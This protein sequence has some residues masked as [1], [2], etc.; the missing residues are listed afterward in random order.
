MEC[1][2]CHHRFS[3]SQHPPDQHVAIE[4]GDNYFSG[5]ENCYEDYH[6]QQHELIRQGKYYSEILKRYAESSSQQSLKVLDIGSAS[7]CILKGMVDDGWRGLGIE[8]N[9][10]MVEYGRNKL[11]VDLHQATIETFTSESKFDAVLLIQMLP[12]LLDPK[13]AIASIRSLLCQG[14]LLLVEA[15]NRDSITA[16]SFGRWWHEYNPPSVLH[17]F[18]KS[19]LRQLLAEN[20]FEFVAVGRPTKWI[21]L[22]N[23]FAI[24]RQSVN[25]SLIGRVCLA[26]TR[27]IPSQWRVPYFLDDVF[28]MIVRKTA[29]E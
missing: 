25:D 6:F 29:D 5:G 21:S 7:G 11:G 24:A 8:P 4:Y 3:K 20:G 12:H 15:W 10:S 27:M 22:G 14:G 9:A 23:G 26:P 2:A 19:S 17:W 1:T 16:R 13:S 18:S 28:W